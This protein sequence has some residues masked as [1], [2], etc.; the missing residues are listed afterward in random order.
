MKISL[1]S[2]IKSKTGNARDKNNYRP[3]A[4]VF[5]ICMLEILKMFL[6]CMSA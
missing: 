5:E 4:L 1:V 6:D 2:N 3:I